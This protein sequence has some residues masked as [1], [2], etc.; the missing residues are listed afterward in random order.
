MIPFPI[1][2]LTIIVN[3]ILFQDVD[4]CILPIVELSL[5]RIDFSLLELK[6]GLKFFTTDT[7]C[8]QINVAK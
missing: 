8:L 2:F 1:P 5:K 7:I 6:L 3:E 4:G